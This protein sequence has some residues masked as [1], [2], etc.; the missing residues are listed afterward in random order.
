MATNEEIKAVN[1]LYREGR[2][3]KEQMDALMVALKESDKSEER[4][5][6]AINDSDKVS[7]PV[8]IVYHVTG[9]NDP[10]DASKI[11]RACYRIKGVQ[12]V[13]T[14]VK[15]G[16]VSVV[17]DVDPD[18]VITTLKNEG[19]IS[20]VRDIIFDF[21]KGYVSNNSS[22]YSNLS[23]YLSELDNEDLDDIDEDEDLDD[24]DEEDDID[25][26]DDVDD[27]DDIDEED[28]DDD[29][30][31]NINENLP[32]LK[33][34]MKTVSS[35][36]KSA[37]KFGLKS[38][39][40]AEKA[41]EDAMNNAMRSI[42]NSLNDKINKSDD[43]SVTIR[44]DGKVNYEDMRIFVKYTKDNEYYVNVVTVDKADELIDDCKQKL[45]SVCFADVERL[46][47]ERFVGKYNR[48]VDGKVVLKVIVEP[49]DKDASNEL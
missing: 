19:F 44:K 16:R 43:L 42:N 11:R 6:K 14:D 2:I 46:V 18:V 28:D 34:L 12:L 1:K 27:D 23:K 47:N 17:G 10:Y 15:T 8:K 33:S 21:K 45:D 26:D 40:K 30:S 3:T 36:V 41:A 22:N 31:V 49:K 7:T 5:T 39:L 37:V 35:K 20:H 29:I 32:G 24:I 13:E 4:N 48:V 38:A 25:E 9:M